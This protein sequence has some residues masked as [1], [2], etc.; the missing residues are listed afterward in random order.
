MLHYRVLCRALIFFGYIYPCV[1]LLKGGNIWS[2]FVNL[3]RLQK[4][5]GCPRICPFN[6]TPELTLPSCI[7]ISL[8]KLRRAYQLYLHALV[9][10]THIIFDITR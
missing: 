10:R 6:K 7:Y 8:L 3:R 2:S 9:C 4:N 5:A 1:L